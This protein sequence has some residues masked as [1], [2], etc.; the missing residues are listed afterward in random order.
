MNRDNKG[1]FVK[2]FIPKTKGKFICKRIIVKCLNCNKDILTKDN[3]RKRKYCSRL[4]ATQY[5][6][7]TGNWCA[8]KG[9]P[10]PKKGI[11][12]NCKPML[13]RTFSLAHRIKISLTKTGKTCF[14]GFGKSR[15]D[16]FRQSKA[17]K[18]WRLSVFHRDSFKCQSCGKVG[19][20][21]EAH[22]IKE[23]S[24]YPELRLSLDN[25]ITLCGECHRNIHKK[26]NLERNKK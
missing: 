10:S 24:L 7:K 21:I 19:N 9:R 12:S 4:C 2:G 8:K 14:S 6:I 1:R 25:G 11:P 26:I 13:G 3:N 5:Q 23:F 18:E 16:L 17:Y 15:S 20:N 22:H